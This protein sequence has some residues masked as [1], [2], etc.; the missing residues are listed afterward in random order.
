MPQPSYLRHSICYDVTQ[1]LR[2]C[3]WNLQKRL[4]CESW[5][6]ILFSQTIWVHSRIGKASVAVVIA[7]HGCQVP[8]EVE[9]NNWNSCH[10]IKF[11]YIL[12]Y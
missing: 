12:Y 3:S 1:W 11:K 9:V 2:P 5:V 6:K 10:F 4:I 7:D 8:Y